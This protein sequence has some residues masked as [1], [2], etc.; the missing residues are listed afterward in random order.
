MIT[1][2]KNLNSVVTTEGLSS[3][4]EYCD[5]S[6]II[7]NYKRVDQLRGAVNSVLS[8]TLHPR[9]IIIIDDCSPMNLFSEIEQFTQTSGLRTNIILLRN[10]RNR[11]A[12]YSRN[13]GIQVAKGKY[14]AFLDSD[15]LWLPQK[16]EIQLSQIQKT[17]SNLPIFSATGRYRVDHTGMIIAKQFG[18]QIIN[19]SKIRS[20]NFIGTLSSIMVDTQAARDIGGFD[21]NLSACQ[22]WDFFIRISEIGKY[23]GVSNTLCVYVDH[24]GSRITL[25][26]RKRV[27][28]HIKIYKKYFKNLKSKEINKHSVYRSIAEDLQ[29]LNKDRLS[30]HFF[31]MSLIEK[32]SILGLTKSASYLLIR[33]YFCYFSMPNLKQDRYNRYRR[34]MKKL[35]KADTFNAIERDQIEIRKLLKSI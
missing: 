14:L 21:T 35:I 10:S 15:D 1:Y 13:L 19:S 12:N 17:S 33:L 27:L 25:N 24:Q 3:N 32:Y 23:I 11:G 29:P 5:V 30:I 9:E 28:A 2:D 26:H 22:D 34:N 8:Q 7:P 16:L 4:M 18:G 31:A 20:S 6:V